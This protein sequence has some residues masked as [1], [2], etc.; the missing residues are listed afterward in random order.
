MH[1]TRSHH[2]I[3]ARYQKILVYA[4][5][6]FKDFIMIHKLKIARSSY[7]EVKIYRIR[8]LKTPMDCFNLFFTLIKGCGGNENNFESQE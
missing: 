4:M 6:R 3:F 2:Q 7:M 5:Q 1:Q 8:S